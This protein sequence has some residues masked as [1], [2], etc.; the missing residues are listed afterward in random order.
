[1]PEAP[2]QDSGLSSHHCSPVRTDGKIVQEGGPD[3][4]GLSLVTGNEHYRDALT[5]CV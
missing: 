4:E 5:L 2:S 1:M 3:G